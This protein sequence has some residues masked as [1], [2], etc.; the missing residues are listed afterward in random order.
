M[1]VAT[2]F[3]VRESVI[4]REGSNTRRICCTQGEPPIVLGLMVCLRVLFLL[5]FIKLF[6]K[7]FKR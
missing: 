7:M 2:K 3:R 5:F 4:R 6:I 1:V